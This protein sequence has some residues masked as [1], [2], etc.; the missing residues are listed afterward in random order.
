MR[1]YETPAAHE[2]ETLSGYVIDRLGRIPRRGDKVELDGAVFEVAAVR[3]RRI[4][5]VTVTKP[6][7]RPSMDGSRTDS[8]DGH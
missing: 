3:R 1:A 2:E 7:E 8:L 6:P 4:A 5:Q